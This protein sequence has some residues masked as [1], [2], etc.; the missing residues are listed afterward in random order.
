MSQEVFDA[1]MAYYVAH[2]DAHKAITA[3]AFADAMARAN[4]AD[5][6][7]LSLLDD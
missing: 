1:L 7:L 4:K 2:K 6:E 3:T 5:C